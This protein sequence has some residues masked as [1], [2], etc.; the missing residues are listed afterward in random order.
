M[1]GGGFGPAGGKAVG[2]L[3]GNPLHV[4]PLRHYSAHLDR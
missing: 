2:G 3:A 1:G 4:R